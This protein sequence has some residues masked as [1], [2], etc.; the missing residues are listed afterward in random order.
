MLTGTRTRNYLAR[1]E[2][3]T[4]IGGTSTADALNMNMKIDATTDT[5]PGIPWIDEP[6]RE[7]TV[8]LI[9]GTTIDAIMRAGEVRIVENVEKR[10]F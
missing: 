7:N 1:N 4:A 3:G 9:Y 2:A 6:M 5:A 10:K 8:M